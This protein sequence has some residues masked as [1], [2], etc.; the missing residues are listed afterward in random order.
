MA[1]LRENQIQS[2]KKAPLRTRKLPVIVKLN[3]SS[4]WNTLTRMPF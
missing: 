4:V 2:D 3:K 1:H